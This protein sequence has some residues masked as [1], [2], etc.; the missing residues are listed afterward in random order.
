MSKTKTVET[1]KLFR[2]ASKTLLDA[3]IEE[4]L[5]RLF[6]NGAGETAQRLVLELENGRNGGGWCRNAVRDQIRDALLSESV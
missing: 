5:N 2:L 4:I 6:T 1:E 3:T